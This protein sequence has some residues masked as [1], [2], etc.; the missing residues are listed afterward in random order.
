M[1]I[2]VIGIGGIG[3]ALLPVLTR[4]LNFAYSDS[5]VTLIDGDNYE[6]KN[7]E[8]QEFDSLGNK[9]QVTVE[10]IA[11]LF[12]NILFL[13]K[14]EYVTDGNVYEVIREGDI[15]F[16]CV[17][18]HNSRKLVSDRC[19]DLQNVTLISGGND[20]TDGNV[21]IYIRREGENLTLPIASDFHPEIMYPEDKNPAEAGCG[22]L[23]ESEPQLL[24]ANNAIASAMLSVFYAYLQG[25][26][27]YDE[28]YIDIL[29]GNS[30]AVNRQKTLVR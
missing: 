30:R 16:L 20:F 9:A 28:I 24:I 1:K 22:E 23:A 12:D 6:S 26:V 2:K 14:D 17:D 11:S 27:H 8:R 18:N 15:V 13:S 7:K 19:E 4:Y 21:Q 29:T 5:E 3:G 10:R 25:K